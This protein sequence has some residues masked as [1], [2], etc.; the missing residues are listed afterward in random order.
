[1]DNW[2]SGKRVEKAKEPPKL[3]GEALYLSLLNLPKGTR[4]DGQRQKAK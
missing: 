1:M 4:K 3:T 2:K